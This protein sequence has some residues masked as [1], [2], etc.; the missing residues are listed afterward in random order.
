MFYLAPQNWHEPYML[1]G[2]EARHLAKVLRLKAGDDLRLMDGYGREGVFTVKSIHKT[3]ITLE[4]VQDWIHPRPAAPAILAV[5]WTKSARR[6]FL[7]EKSVECEASQIWFWQAE[8]SQFPIPE[9]AK[10]NWQDQLISAAKQS[11]NP[12]LPIIRTMPR[13]A[14][15]LIAAA[16]EFEHRFVLLEEDH[17]PPRIL[18]ADI[19]AQP[20]TSIYVIGPEGGLSPT[21]AQKFTQAGFMPV[22]LGKRVL[23]WET[24]ALLCLGLHWWKSNNSIEP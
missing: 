3:E 11:R 10:Q 13:G 4:L 22:S 21:E 8:R 19:L 2:Q 1:T 24:A 17:N 6:G 23:R 20:G 7:L 12:W 14:D 5:A 18:S 9:K 15:E 16:C